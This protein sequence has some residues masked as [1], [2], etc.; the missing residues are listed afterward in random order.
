MIELSSLQILQI[1]RCPHRGYHQHGK[2]RYEDICKAKFSRWDLLSAV[3]L[4]VV[5]T[6]TLAPRLE[7]PRRRPTPARCS[8]S[9]CSPWSCPRTGSASSQ[10]GQ[11]SSRVSSSCQIWSGIRKS[12]I[13]SDTSSETSSLLRRVLTLDSKVLEIAKELYEKRSLLIMGR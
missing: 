12:R 3:S 9:P 8:R 2:P 6:S 13:S 5:S 7:L 4:T 1:Q 10:G 11:R